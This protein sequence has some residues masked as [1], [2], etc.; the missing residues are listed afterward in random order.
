[1]VNSELTIRGTTLDP[2]AFK[3]ALRELAFDEAASGALRDALRWALRLG[4]NYI[5]TEHLLLGLLF[6][7]GAVTEAL[8]NIGLSQQRAEQLINAELAAYRRIT[9]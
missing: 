4:H 6:A 1:M 9:G 8:S 7:G 5:G 2:K 3:A